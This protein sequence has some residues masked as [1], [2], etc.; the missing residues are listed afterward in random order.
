MPHTHVIALLFYATH[1][2]TRA[3]CQSVAKENNNREIYMAV[4]IATVISVH[5]M[6]CECMYTCACP[7]SLAIQ[8]GQHIEGGATGHV[9]HFRAAVAGLPHHSGGGLHVH[10]QG[11]G[12]QGQVW[13]DQRLR[14]GTAREEQSTCG[15]TWSQCHRTLPCHICHLQWLRQLRRLQDHSLA[16][17]SSH[18]CLWHSLQLG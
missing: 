4:T 14:G 15:C 1:A 13:R 2:I 11:D 3:N 16:L 17:D 18:V 10:S 8:L 5:V 9:R 7:G 6:T 12:H